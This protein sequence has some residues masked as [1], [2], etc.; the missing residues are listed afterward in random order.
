MVDQCLGGASLSAI[1]V[2]NGINPNLL[3]RW[4]LEHER[5][6]LHGLDDTAAVNSPTAQKP[7]APASWLPFVP[8][9]SAVDVPA[10][11][12][13]DQPDWPAGTNT[14][15][16]PDTIRVEV[17]GKT[18]SL[19]VQWPMAQSGQLADWVRELLA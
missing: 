2:D 10:R 9:K 11:T 13:M 15:A 5:L 12:M 6:G 3:R 4:V 17:S 1:A 19:S 14:T 16:A 8:V 18:L 7:V